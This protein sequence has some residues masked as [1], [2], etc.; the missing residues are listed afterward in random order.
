MI[1]HAVF[2]FVPT[3]DWG[4]D[5]QAI[6]KRWAAGSYKNINVTELKTQETCFCRR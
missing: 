3:P 5:M 4:L 2:I 1:L 6:Q